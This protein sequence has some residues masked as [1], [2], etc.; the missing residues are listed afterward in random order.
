MRELL[1][2]HSSLSE[3]PLKNV[4]LAQNFHGNFRE[5]FARG[6]KVSAVYSFRRT[7]R[8]MWSET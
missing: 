8:E 2:D 6:L 1:E 7:L 5:I 4:G 3:P